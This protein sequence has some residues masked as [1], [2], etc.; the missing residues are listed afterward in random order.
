MTRTPPA[1]ADR[2]LLGLVVCGLLAVGAGQQA[3][4]PGLGYV[5]V[6]EWPSQAAT[7][8]TTD[9]PWTF[10]Q[11]AAVATTTQGR[12]LVL[13]RGANPIRMFHADGRFVRSWGDG[14]FSEGKVGAIAPADRKAGESGYSAAYG[15]AGCDSC[16]AHSVRVDPDGNIWVVD[17]P[18]HV[19]Y[20]MDSEGGVIMQLGT[21]GLSGAGRTTFYLPTDVAFAP[22]GD[23][24]VS[25]GY[26]N[27]RIV[28]Y[29]R[30]GEYLLEW[31]T[32]GTGPGEFGLPHNLV[33]DREGRV[34]V[35]DRDN[36]RVQ[37][38]D[39]DGRFVTQWPD[40][41]IVS[42]LF[43]TSDQRIWTGGVLR[44]LDGTVVGRLPD[45]RGAHGTTVAGSDDVYLA[46]LSGR[47]QKFSTH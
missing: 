12:I 14:L 21:K 30:D 44:D 3:D 24:Y 15:S 9:A 11:V 36:Q 45:G 28:K 6:R 8:T 10:G 27:A 37:V 41:G 33:V 2:R 31:G 46:Q 35:T 16:G 26:G 7:A 39:A 4:V 34:Y 22:T 5:E 18:G 23:L 38:F 42:S 43:I 17:A 40:I 25:D 47:V 29:T 20:K 19:V 13:H 1:R 32:R